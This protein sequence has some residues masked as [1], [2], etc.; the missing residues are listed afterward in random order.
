[1]HH[2]HPNLILFVAYTFVACLLLPAL[3]WIPPQSE[4]HPWEWCFLPLTLL[5]CLSIFGNRIDRVEAAY[6]YLVLMGAVS[7][8]LWLI[9]RLLG[10]AFIH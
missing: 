3:G 6:P 2:L 5:P 1:M 4:V 7:V 8:L 10:W 9:S